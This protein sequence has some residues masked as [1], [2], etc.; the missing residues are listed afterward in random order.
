MPNNV[1]GVGVIGARDPITAEMYM[2]PAFTFSMTEE[3]TTDV[4][5]GFP[6]TDCAPLQDL[7]VADKQ[8]QFT[9]T[10]GTQILDRQAVNWILFN[11]KRQTSASI[12][13]PRLFSGVIALG[14]LTVTGLTVDQE[15][16]SVVILQDIA[17]GNI[18]LTPQDS[19]GSITTDVFEVSANT[20][21]VDDSY[22]GKTAIVYYRTTESSIEITGGNTTYSPY[23]NVELFAK[24]CTT[25]TDPHRIWIPRAT[26]LNGLNVDPK[27]DEFTR[28]FRALL[29]PGFTVPYVEFTAL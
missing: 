8:S 15:N 13:L 3:R 16:V 26:S 19:G 4:S 25:R 24:I 7:D 18:S 5:S 28:E 20:I 12:E 2:S 21:T 22:D 6:T 27:A 1:K 11:N 10:M 23:Q 14:T 9:V 29:P 17:P